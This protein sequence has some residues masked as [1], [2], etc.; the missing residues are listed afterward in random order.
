MA[1]QNASNGVAKTCDSCNVT[2]QAGAGARR[3][4]CP[5]CGHFYDSETASSRKS[6]RPTP[7]SDTPE[8]VSGIHM[9]GEINLPWKNVCFLTGLD[10][11]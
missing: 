4:I 5:N 10:L 6:D 1:T 9:N 8:N 3:T 7:E 11:D 2:V